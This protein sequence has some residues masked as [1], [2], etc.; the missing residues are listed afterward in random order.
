MADLAS[1]HRE[2]TLHQETFESQKSKAKGSSPAFLPNS[3]GPSAGL[4]NHPRICS[5]DRVMRKHEQMTSHNCS[6]SW[7]VKLTVT[8]PDQRTLQSLSRSLLVPLCS[9]GCLLLL[10][11]SLMASGLLHLP[12]SLLPLSISFTGSS[13]P[14]RPSNV[15]F[16]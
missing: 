16:L 5:P 2:R 15:V 7:Q 12:N 14:S 9:P 6:T 3:S 10:K 4:V 1:D 11:P 13:S 8:T